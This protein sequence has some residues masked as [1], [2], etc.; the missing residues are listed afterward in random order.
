[1][2]SKFLLFIFGVSL[3]LSVIKEPPNLTMMSSFP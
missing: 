1:M 3:D 2:D